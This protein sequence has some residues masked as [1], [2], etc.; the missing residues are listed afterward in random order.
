MKWS[1]MTTA[2]E[3]GLTSHGFLLYTDWTRLVVMEVA[4]FGKRTEALKA[5]CGLELGLACHYICHFLSGKVILV[6]TG[7]RLYEV[8]RKRVC[9]QEQY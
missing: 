6:T 9:S 7:G 3:I 2:E 4:G 1:R 8:T 5:S